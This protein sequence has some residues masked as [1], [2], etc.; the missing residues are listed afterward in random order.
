METIFSQIDQGELAARLGSIN[1]YDRRGNIVFME[2]FEGAL[3]NWDQ[4]N[5][6]VG[7]G[8]VLSAVYSRHGSQAAQLT[9]GSGANNYTLI[10]KLWPMPISTQIGLEASFTTDANLGRVVID[11][12]IYDGTNLYSA[13]GGV[14][15]T[16]DV[17]Y[18]IDPIAGGVPF[19]AALGLTSSNYL[20]HTLKLVFDYSTHSWMR[21]MFDNYSFNASAYNVVTALSAI[22]PRM[23]IGI[24]AINAGAGNPVIYVD[25]VILTQNEPL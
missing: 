11:V 17:A 1:T 25:D 18:I 9:A 5:A 2:D 8:S 14:D 16:A 20:F 10:E 21:A 4:V 12:G 13:T 23:L 6:G 19:T 15:I 7:A 3:F 24:W 22:T